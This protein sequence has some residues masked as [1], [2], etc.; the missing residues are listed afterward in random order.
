LKASPARLEEVLAHLRR[1]PNDPY[2]SLRLCESVRPTARP[3]DEEDLTERW[4]AALARVASHDP[5]WF[6]TL[7]GPDAG[8]LGV[9]GAPP[10]A[11]AR[12]EELLSIADPSL[13]HYVKGVLWAEALRYEKPAAVD[14]LRHAADHL[15]QVDERHRT[16]RYYEDLCHALE[17]V[18]YAGARA[19]FAPLLAAEDDTPHPQVSAL[20]MQGR[21]AFVL[22]AAARAADWETYDV[23]RPRHDAGVDAHR[24]CRIL[25][26]D[27]L[28]ELALGRNDRLAEILAAMTT[29]AA[30]VMFL[31]GKDDT[32]FVEA[33][34]ERRLHLEECRA[35][36]LATR[37]RHFG[38]RAKELLDRLDG[39]DA[40][41]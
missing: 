6:V 4:V 28:R 2:W 19:Y 16:D 15:L 11:L 3:S 30:N 21:V 13:D 8:R 39:G 25:S 38:G 24:D 29:R 18:D 32:A 14:G 27:G 7:A 9:H 12:V 10:A 26:C 35:Y 31:G 36:L 17:P 33:L 41:S 22:V 37:G 20:V 23:H 34:V 5:V 40:S 1:H